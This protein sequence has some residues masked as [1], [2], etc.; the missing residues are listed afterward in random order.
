MTQEERARESMIKWLSHPDELG[1]APKNLT[2]AEIFEYDGMK[3]YIFKFRTKLLSRK[4]YVGVCGGFEGDSLEHCGHVF[5]EMAEF[6]PLTAHDNAVRMI[7]MIKEYWRGQAEEAVPEE[8]IREEASEEEAAAFD[9]ES[10]AFASRRIT[11]DGCAVGYMFREEPFGEADSGWRFLAGDETAE[12]LNGSNT[13]ML[14][15]DTLC[16]FDESVIPYL[17]LP[18]GTVLVRDGEK[19]ISTNS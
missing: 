16:G 1:E 18:V 8:D 17:N 19:F 7:E 4:W 9:S 3:Y 6:S 15:M 11:A 10:V 12:Y 14:T 5:S 2:V 13:E